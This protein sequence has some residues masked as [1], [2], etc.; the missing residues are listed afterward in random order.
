MI[1]EYNPKDTANPNGSRAVRFPTGRRSRT[2]C[3]VTFVPVY[4]PM[5]RLAVT[6]STNAARASTEAGGTVTGV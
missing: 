2:L 4:A 5:P 3:G 1:A 6:S